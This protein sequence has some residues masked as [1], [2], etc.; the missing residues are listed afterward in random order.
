MKDTILSVKNLSVMIQGETILENISFDI[1]KGENLM[2]VG[3]NGAG[4][5]ILIK[6]ILNL[7]P[8]KNGE[9]VWKTNIK[10]SYIPQG[11]LPG[12]EMPITSLEFLNLKN[13]SHKFLKEKLEEV[14]LDEKILKKKIANLS[15]GE[16]QRLMIVWSLMGDPDILIF[17]EPTSGI[18]TKGEEDIYS[19][20]GRISKEKNLASIL[21]THDLSV[22]HSFADNV[23]C[24]NKESVC[25]GA[26]EIALTPETLHKLYG[27]K[28]SLYSHNH[29]GK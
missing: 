1:K 6:S 5:S 16:F 3:P 20:L 19:L 2:I 18:D 17:D 8:K 15:G 14:G 11:F 7:L 10:T 26:P 27:E 9:V 21:V 13:N 25:F 24:L 28:I 12:A 22:V 29:N 23:L 4:K